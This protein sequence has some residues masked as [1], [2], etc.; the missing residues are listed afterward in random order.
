MLDGGLEASE[1][2]DVLAAEVD[3]DERAEVAVLE[4]LLAESRVA[5]DQ[6]LDDV[7]DGVAGRLELA[8]PTS[9]GLRRAPR[10]RLAPVT[11]RGVGRGAPPLKKGAA[12]ESSLARTLV[13]EKRGKHGFPHEREPE[14]SS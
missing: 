3:V 13:A 6:I 14:D 8:P 12:R 4:E 10:A 5:L 2:P 7:A 11:G 1:H 9:E